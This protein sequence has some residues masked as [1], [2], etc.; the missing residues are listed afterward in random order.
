MLENYVLNL[1]PINKNH[2]WGPHLSQKHAQSTDLD[3][4]LWLKNL[5]PKKYLRPNL[6]DFEI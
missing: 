3:E 1:H 4:Y 6:D 5:A 2:I